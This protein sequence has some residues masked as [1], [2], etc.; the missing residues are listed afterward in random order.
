MGASVS[1]SM[2]E[3]YAGNTMRA[4]A[5]GYAVNDNIS[6]NVGQ[7]AYSDEGDFGANLQLCW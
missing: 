4:I 2:N 5:L 6:L 3:D 7:T 1:A